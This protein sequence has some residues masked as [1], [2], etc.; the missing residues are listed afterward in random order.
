MKELITITNDT[1]LLNEETSLLIAEFERQ[2]KEIKIQEEELKAEILKEMEERGIT[3]LET[4]E[5]SISYIYPYDREVF[6][7]KRFRDEHP[8][9]YDEY[10]KFTPVKSSIRI[11]TKE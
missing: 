1:A 7:T 2:A 5:L 8:C 9:E 6:D 10:C 3:K 4:P 11:R